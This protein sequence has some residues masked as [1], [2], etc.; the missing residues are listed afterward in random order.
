MGNKNLISFFLLGEGRVK[1]VFVFCGDYN[2]N[3]V[4]WDV[5]F[6]EWPHIFIDD[7]C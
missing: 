1:K 2:F 3:K 6:F 7:F 5:V 4:C